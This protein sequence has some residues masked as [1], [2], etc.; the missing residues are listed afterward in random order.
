MAPALPASNSAHVIVLGNEKGGS[1]K[2][3]LAM[4]II[5]ALLKAGHRVASIDTDSRQLSLT[6]YLENRARWARRSGLALELPSHFSVKLGEGEQSARG[7]GQRVRRFHRDRR[8]AGR[9]RGFR[10]HR[11]PGQR[12]L[13]H[14]AEPRAWPIRWSRRSTTASSISTCSVASRARR[15]RSPASASMPAWSRRCGA[16]GSTSVPRGTDWVVVRNRLSTLS[17]RNQRNVIEGLDLLAGHLGFRVANG[18][19]ERVVFRELFPMGLT[20]FDPVR[21]RRARHPAD[22]VACRRARRNPRSG[23]SLHLPVRA[24]A[25]APLAEEDGPCHAAAGR[26]RR[27]PAALALPQK[28]GLRRASRIG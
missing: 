23:R 8:A 10:R 14:A 12:F 17:S 5:V 19:S 3:T 1:G 2:S 27:A 21:A 7:R 24:P 11:H 9:D 22:H 26:R 28:G 13:P 25:I 4:H 15:W 16:S 18:I 20:A 6:R